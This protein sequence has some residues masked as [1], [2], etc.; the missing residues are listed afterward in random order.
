[1]KPSEVVAVVLESREAGHPVRRQQTQRI[2][3]LAA[4]TLRQLPTLEHNVLDAE[5]GQAAAHG[6]PCLSGADDDRRRARHGLPQRVVTLTST[7]TPLVSTS[8]TAERARDCST[9]SR[10][11]S[12]GASPAIVK[13]MRMRS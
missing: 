2:P 4:P 1:M 10:S 5:L 12:G 8:N 11:F 13:L 9:I 7:G 6:E 3:A